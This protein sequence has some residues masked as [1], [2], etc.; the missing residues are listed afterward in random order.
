MPHSSHLTMLFLQKESGP[1]TVHQGLQS[2]KSNQSV[3]LP[4]LFPRDKWKQNQKLRPSLLEM[5]SF[6]IG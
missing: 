4:K 2:V 5:K 6:K 3:N 1:A